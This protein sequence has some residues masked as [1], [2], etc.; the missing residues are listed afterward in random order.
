MLGGGKTLLRKTPPSK[1]SSTNEGE[2]KTSSVQQHRWTLL[3]TRPT[4]Q[5]MN[6]RV[7]QFELEGGYLTTWKIMKT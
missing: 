2:V 4:V 6:K 5:A 1:T 7:I 3:S